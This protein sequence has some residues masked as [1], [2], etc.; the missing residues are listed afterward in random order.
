MKIKFIFL[1]LLAV[2]LLSCGNLLELGLKAK[3]HM[4]DADSGLIFYYP[5]NGNVHD[6]SGNGHDG[7]I[8]GSCYFNADDRFG[9]TGSVFYGI[10]SESSYMDTG[11]GNGFNPTRAFSAN[12]WVWYTDSINDGGQKYFFGTGA[13]SYPPAGFRFYVSK[14]DDTNQIKFVIN[15]DGLT[16]SE[17][18]LTFNSLWISFRNNNWHMLTAVHEKGTGADKMHIYVDG[19]ERTPDSTYSYFQ[20][21]TLS[22]NIYILAASNLN[23]S[24]PAIGAI[25]SYGMLDDFRF[26]SRALSRTEIN[27][28]YHEGDFNLK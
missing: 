4:Y 13:D 14:D 17:D 8:Y 19:I 25:P 28:L 12:F 11:W 22:K 26:Y 16:S 7:T 10:I 3:D 1:F 15:N 23:A 9:K 21:G 5:F 27:A 6:S 18:S 2:T 24:P 20:S